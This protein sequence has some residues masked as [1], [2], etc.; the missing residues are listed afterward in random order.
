MSICK[1]RE[2]IDNIRKTVEGPYSGP[3]RAIYASCPAVVMMV[4]GSG[5]TFVLSISQVVQKDLKSKVEQ[6][7]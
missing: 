1:K 6:T 3:G 5:I 7:R 2:G 4:G